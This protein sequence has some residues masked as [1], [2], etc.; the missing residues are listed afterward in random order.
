LVVIVI[1][2]SAGCLTTP[3]SVLH[4]TP[5]RVRLFKGIAA[6]AHPMG[7]DEAYF[8]WEVSAFMQIG[9]AVDE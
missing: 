7:P 9:A 6:Q 2:I 1:V 4:G 5:V 3:Y 8:E